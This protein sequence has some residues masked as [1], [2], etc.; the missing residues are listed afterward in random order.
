MNQS[1]VRVMTVE[2]RVESRVTRA[3]SRVIAFSRGRILRLNQHK[4]KDNEPLEHGDQHRDKDNEPL[5][6]R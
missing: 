5:E 2:S 4:D 6:W 1:C 3:E